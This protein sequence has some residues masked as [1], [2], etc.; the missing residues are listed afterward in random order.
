[1]VE[2]SLVNWLVALAGF[3]FL[4]WQD[5]TLDGWLDERIAVVMALVGLPLAFFQHTQTA[6]VIILAT[7]AVLFLAIQ[8]I[9]RYSKETI[10][11]EGDAYTL[12]ALWILLPVPAIFLLTLVLSG[13]LTTAY[14]WYSKKHLIPYTIFLFGGLVGA[15]VVNYFGLV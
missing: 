14:A 3:A 11:G 15:M 9:A 6:F 8:A 2:V 4:G 1:M 5:W 12:A 7:T 13:V 10:M